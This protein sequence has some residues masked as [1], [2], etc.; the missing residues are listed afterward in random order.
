[1][2]DRPAMEG[3]LHLRRFRASRLDLHQSGLPQLQV[4]CD[5]N[6]RTVHGPVPGTTHGASARLGILSHINKRG[7]MGR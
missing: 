5:R 4:G 1:M 3:V 6:D 7:R 2:D